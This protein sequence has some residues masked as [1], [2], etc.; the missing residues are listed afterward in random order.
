M[1]IVEFHK[2]TELK[3]KNIRGF[4]KRIVVI[5][6]TSA[7]GSRSKDEAEVTANL[8]SVLQTAKLQSNNPMNFITN[9]LYKGK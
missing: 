7:N 1:K 3:V 2:N 6:G 9:L 4:M 5:S 8:L